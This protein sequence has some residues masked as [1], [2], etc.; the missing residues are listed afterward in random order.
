MDPVDFHSGK[1]WKEA[2]A[3]ADMLGFQHR[4]ARVEHHVPDTVEFDGSGG[5]AGGARVDKVEVDEPSALP[6][7][8]TSTST[9]LAGTLSVN[10]P[11]SSRPS[12]PLPRPLSEELASDLHREH[13]W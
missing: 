3:S 8:S 12:E 10:A 1:E 7:L 5:K 2:A 6:P 11:R 4:A 9:T 13:R